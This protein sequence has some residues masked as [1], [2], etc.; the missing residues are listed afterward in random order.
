[1]MVMLPYVHWQLGVI[2]LVPLFGV[3]WTI[4]ALAAFGESPGV[5]RSLALGT[6]FAVTYF[7]CNYHGLFLSLLL[8]LTGGC[9]LGRNLWN[10]RTW[11]RL[12]PGAAWCLLLIGP[13]ISVQRE[14]SKQ[15]DWKRPPELIERLSAEWGDF[16]AT[17]WPQLLPLREFVDPRR[18]GWT[19][20]PGY[21]KMGL[22]V[23]GMI[24]GLY[25]SRLRRLTLFLTLFTLLSL[26]LAMGPKF[27]LGDWTPYEWIR[28]YYPGMAMARNVYR[29]VVF[30]QM[31]IVLLAA[32]SLDG[33][34]RLLMGH[35][36]VG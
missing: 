3:V 1:M 21:L 12:L 8:I 20:S 24:W 19:L 35:R 5:L 25:Y 16:T 36:E 11:P 22:A 15:H 10:W 2:Q 33:F 17:P 26:L 9:L 7:L 18:S 29:F 14:V 23:F 28:L 32:I 31:G 4:H 6:A 27:H 30:A 34:R 13:M